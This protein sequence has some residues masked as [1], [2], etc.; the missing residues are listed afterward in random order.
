MIKCDRFEQQ[1]SDYLEGEV[2][3]E[4]F[5][6]LN[7]HENSCNKCADLVINARILSKILKN[8][9]AINASANFTKNLR[10]KLAG[11][12]EL[13]K[14]RTVK[15]IVNDIKSFKLKPVA[16]SFAAAASIFFAFIMLDS[17]VINDRS[18]VLMSPRIE[19]P[20][21]PGSNQSPNTNQNLFVPNQ[22]QV[23]GFSTS[24]SLEKFF[25]DAVGES[26][27]RED[28]SKTPR[29]DSKH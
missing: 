20:P 17:Y 26:L 27:M 13:Q 28:P 7:E 5:K 10:L 3:E 23:G 4:N 9:P 21:L 14:S 6:L 18:D 22:T 19:M 16:I 24:D 1:V 12:T 2:S 29:N 25:Q 15:R 11:E 8:L